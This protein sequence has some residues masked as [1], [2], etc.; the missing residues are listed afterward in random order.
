[1]AAI[2]SLRVELEL[3]D[4]SFT[5]R[6]I[7]AGTS[8]NQLTAAAGQTI[9]AVRRLDSALSDAGETIKNSV[10]TLGLARA[11][12]E[13][14]YTVFGSWAVSIARTGGEIERLTTLI[15]GLSEATTDIERLQD[16]E[17]AT[18]WI[19]D[20]ARNA[21]FAVRELTDSFV[22]FRAGGLDPT[23]GSMQGLVDAVAAFGG[24]G[25]TLQR[26]SIAIQQMAGKGVISMEELRQQLGEAVPSALPLLA[27]ALN[28]SVD[29]LVKNISD[30][31]VRAE[32]ALR[33]MFNEFERTFGGRAQAM[34]ATFNGQVQQV[35]NNWQRLQMTAAGQNSGGTVMQGGFLDRL[36]VAMT[37]LNEALSSQ[38][39]ANFAIEVGRNLAGLVDGFVAVAEA[40]YRWR[41]EIGLIA[42]GLA[43][44][45]GVRLAVGI[46]SS[47][48]VSITA[49]TLALG[50]WTAGTPLAW[51]GTVTLT[52]AVGALGA[53]YVATTAAIATGS[54]AIYTAAAV[55]LPALNAGLAAI[56]ALAVRG[57]ASF[58]AFLSA[59]TML[60]VGLRALLLWPAAIA[61]VVSAGA[62][63]WSVGGALGAIGV[64][65][66][67]LPGVITPA[68]SGL[69]RV[70]AELT[71]RM[72]RFFTDTN[73][74]IESLRMGSTDRTIIQS[75]AD[76]ALQ[77]RIRAGDAAQALRN[78]ST[79]ARTRR[80][81]DELASPF[82]MPFLNGRGLV[83]DVA[84]GYRSGVRGRSEAMLSAE[85][86]RFRD[87]ALRKAEEISGLVRDAET[88]A[89]EQN[90]ERVADARIRGI[91]NGFQAERALY[92]AFGREI[93][94]ARRMVD[95]AFAAGNLTREERDRQR[96]ELNATNAASQMAL[97]QKEL[98]SYQ[99]ALE[100]ARQEFAQAALSGQTVAARSAE[101]TA[102]R[103]EAAIKTVRDRMEA[104]S[105]EGAGSMSGSQNQALLD[106]QAQTQIRNLEARIAQVTAQ[107]EG[108]GGE[109]ER[110]NSLIAAG[111]WGRVGEEV[112]ATM[113]AAAQQVDAAEAALK[114][115]RD[116]QQALSS[117]D[118]G[119]D[120]AQR[121][122]Q[123]YVDRLTD[124]TLP[125][126][127]RS[128]INFQREMEEA[129]RKVGIAT[130]FVGD[131]YI[132]ASAKVT[133]ALD[134]ARQSSAI[135][136]VEGFLRQTEGA[137]T[138]QLP[139]AERLNRQLETIRRDRD[140][141]LS[142]ASTIS[143][144]TR[145][146][147]AINRITTNALA[148]E[149]QARRENAE[150]LTSAGRGAENMLTRLQ[151]RLAELRA[152]TVDG[153]GEL[154]K[155]QTLLARPGAPT[156]A[157]A[158][159]IL[160]T[161]R[162]IDEQ[163]AR[164][165]AATDAMN[166]YREAESQIRESR[167]RT[168]EYQAQLADP[169]LAEGNRQLVV[170]RARMEE[171]VAR[172][173]EAR[174]LLE[175]DDTVG[176]AAADRRITDAEARAGLA[177]QARAGELASQNAVRMREAD[178]QIRESLAE[179]NADRLRLG[180]IAISR[181]LEQAMSLIRN[182]N[183]TAQE[184]MR[185]EEAVT[186]FIAARREQ[187]ARQTE[188]AV[189]SQMRSWGRL[190]DN[191][192]QMWAN[193]MDSML[194]GLAQFVTTGKL[195]MNDLAR[196]M[197]ADIARVQ[198]RAAASGI[199]KMLGGLDLF[200]SGAGAGAGSG[201]SFPTVTA[202][203]GTFHAG[204]MVGREGAPFTLPA[205]LWQ[206][207]P[208]F[209]SGTMLAGD[210]VAAVL[211]KGEGVFTAGQIAAIGRM[212]HSYTMVEGLLAKMAQAFQA[213]LSVA[214]QVSDAPRLNDQA[215][216]G[217]VIINLTNQS[218]QP[219]EAAAGT[220]RFD[221]EGMIID[222]VV[223]AMQRPGKM[224]DAV[225]GA[226]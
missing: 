52:G 17:R 160:E 64:A 60:Q 130:D 159:Q 168:G 68:F 205:S 180:E 83:D 163:Q 75:M 46:Y 45:M 15:R 61:A 109:L 90:A 123:G 14:L 187:L 103:F 209:H 226:V 208:R 1:M 110:I 43:A 57:M 74:G 23:T 82:N 63:L 202:S 18:R 165:R 188:S 80:D 120:R 36:T 2:G 135:G 72:R 219:V 158:Q 193:Q 35:Q 116:A 51:A 41:S 199:F 189:E 179:T 10:V 113:R 24:T 198:L 58:A 95:G 5:T 182:S 85:L 149:A 201:N 67:A 143:D 105:Q 153:T 106:Q 3:A 73:S 186:S 197:I 177:I 89:A 59:G 107:S 8:L 84:G 26:A 166:A 190:T 87:E 40:A 161:A 218:G 129:L 54:A 216:A 213:P 214:P 20:L 124:P 25:E 223:T 4:G 96:A 185:A 77:L 28:Q 6:V 162:A 12:V 207:A 170:F 50:R 132:N 108:L 212:N 178:Q 173:R 16:G 94:N 225:R 141:A 88:R 48:A 156:G 39:A 211:Q 70:V 38:G 42:G 11:A 55:A 136:V 65:A 53:A 196:S 150:A 49:A 169:N 47:L 152:E 101:A 127:Q 112:E 181:D 9:V 71:E 206:N 154:E 171:M 148:A 111:R 27:R 66:L 137:L 56:A 100:T 21:P 222:V 19:L 145:S 215:R 155:Y 167:S 86:T 117:I 142:A 44:L 133:R 146:L 37:R 69:G 33:A 195:N 217:N 78:L 92:F 126:A 76:E 91:Q 32:P 118:T 114:R 194:D 115:F 30:G 128:F 119:L 121:D 22:K 140:R 203:G 125:E 139:R 102:A 175:P 34:M 62:L 151:A 174:R 79:A 183:L 192:G 200:G 99:Q 93:E 184:Q 176:I 220:P 164:L 104:L 98:D 131:A 210:E 81:P 144:P 147:E 138:N 29:E 122:L 224:R 13:N 7:R 221:A 191:M 134:A 172:A 31:R 204:G 97:Y 157:M